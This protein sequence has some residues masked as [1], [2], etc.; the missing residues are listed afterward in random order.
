LARPEQA[1]SAGADPTPLDIDQHV[2]LA[3]GREIQPLQPELLRLI[4]D[5]G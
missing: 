2:L 5:D 1:L 3:R 4:E